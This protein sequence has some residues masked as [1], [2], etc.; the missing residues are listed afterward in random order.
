VSE[1]RIVVGLDQANSA[2]TLRVIGEGVCLPLCD[3]LR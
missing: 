2:N 1:D 3:S